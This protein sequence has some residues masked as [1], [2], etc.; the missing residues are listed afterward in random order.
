MVLADVVGEMKTIQLEAKD[1]FAPIVYLFLK[2]EE[3]LY[4]GGSSVGLGRVAQSFYARRLAQEATDVLLFPCESVE[5]SRSLE[6]S[7]IQN[8]KPRYNKQHVQPSKRLETLE[9]D[10]KWAESKA[11]KKKWRE[12]AKAELKAE[13]IRTQTQSIVELFPLK[14][15]RHSKA[16]PALVV[17]IKNKLE[18]LRR[19]GIIS[20]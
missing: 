8:F 4:I 15:V 9:N 12:E 1:V 13:M 20:S 5:H 19:E 3:V 11:Q 16:L 6:I 10:L 7:M 14:R 2:Q 17:E 18:A